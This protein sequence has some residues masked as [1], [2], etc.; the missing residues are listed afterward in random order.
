MVKK[1]L[2]L[3]FLFAFLAV[4]AQGA[5]ADSEVTQVD[6]TCQWLSES[7]G[8]DYKFHAKE[9]WSMMWWRNLNHLF[10]C[11][12]DE[13][14]LDGLMIGKDSWNL[15]DRENK[16]NI[17]QEFGKAYYVNEEGVPTG[18]WQGSYHGYYDSEWQFTLYLNLKG[19]GEYQ[20]LHA[21]LVFSSP[22]DDGNYPVTGELHVTGK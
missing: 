17:V 19:M 10:D 20:D 11:N 1:V 13:D 6:G 3:V 2:L 9:D 21:K 12:F 5:L 4:P 18:L 14:R 7:E 8:D 22:D 16:E 15:L